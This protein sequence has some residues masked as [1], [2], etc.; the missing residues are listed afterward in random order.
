MNNHALKSGLYIGLITIVVSL[1]MYIVDPTSFAIWWLQILLFIIGVAILVT[2]FGIQYRKQE[3]GYLTFGKAWIHSMITFVVAGF[4]GTIF[5]ILLFTVIDPELANV[6][7]DAVVEKT[8]A[9]MVSFGMPED[10]LDEALE[11][12]RTDTL[13]R[14]TVAGS[15]KGFAW[16]L[17]FYAILSLITGAIVKKKEPENLV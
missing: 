8:E 16:S 5:S 14:F 9:M 11:K 12:T 4:L 2:Y 3:G 15:L 17:I 7:T 1:L 10:Q 13:E 6:V